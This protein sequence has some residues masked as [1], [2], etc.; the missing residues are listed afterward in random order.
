[1]HWSSSIL[2]SE[3]ATSRFE[4]RCDRGLFLALAFGFLLLAFRPVATPPLPRETSRSAHKKDWSTKS[5]RNR[6]FRMTKVANS[7][8]AVQ[9][10]GTYAIRNC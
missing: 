4:A 10:R 7:M 9:G 5:P 1:M 6:N 8:L 3:K 2:E